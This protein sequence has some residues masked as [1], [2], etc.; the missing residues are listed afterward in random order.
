MNIKISYNSSIVEADVK[1][2]NVLDVLSPHRIKVNNEKKVLRDALS[3]PLHEPR[4]K[5]FLAGAKN[6]LVILND[7]TKPT[8]TSRILEFLSG[9]ITG[10]KFRFIIAAG[11]HRPPTKDD[12]KLIFGK[13]YSKFANR[14]FIHDAKRDEDM[15]YIGTTKRKTEIYINRLAVEADKLLVVGSVEPHYFAGY[16]GGRKAIIPGIASYKTIEANHCFALSPDATSLKLEGNPVHED[17]VEGLGFFKKEIFSI[18]VVLNHNKK[19]YAAEA[20]NIID[21]HELVLEKAND[22]FVVRASGK[23]DIVVTVT[24]SPWDIN[25]YQSQQ[26]IENGKRILKNHGILILVSACKRGIGEG[27]YYEILSSCKT[28]HEVI[29]KVNAEP[30]KLGAHKAKRIAELA[31]RAEFWAVTGL[32]DDE[33]R[34]IFIKPYHDIKRAIED[35]LARKGRNAKISFVLDGAI[36]VP[37][38]Q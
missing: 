8:P 3:I 19:I 21:S 33:A 13:Y 37:V 10:D 4:L 11:A 35:A 30:Y 22:V 34:K 24:K 14:I 15:I 12:L 28:P 26:A 31:S 16:T 36:T 20:G 7:N 5:R 2:K 38:L 18:Q 17:L 27:Y 6:I 1:E 23:A 25:F 32:K 29:E 9:Y